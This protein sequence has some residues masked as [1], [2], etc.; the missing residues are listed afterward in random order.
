MSSRQV[1]RLAKLLKVMRIFKLK[2]VLPLLDVFP[3]T[4]HPLST[5][6]TARAQQRAS[7][8]LSAQARS[9]VPCGAVSLV[10]LALGLVYYIHTGA[11]LLYLDLSATGALVANATEAKEAP[12][13]H[14]SFAVRYAWAFAWMVALTSGNSYASPSEL[15]ASAAAMHGASQNY[16]SSSFLTAVMLCGLVVRAYV[17]STATMV[18]MAMRDRKS[19]SNKLRQ[20]FKI[21]LSERGVR[22]TLRRDVRHAAAQRRGGRPAMALTG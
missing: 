15:V 3:A 9:S 5:H 14:D 13:E 12:A 2:R 10:P 20:R 11:C 19:E 16:E 8:S 17:I 18:G 4:D 22:L 1:L 6:A 21:L 7:R